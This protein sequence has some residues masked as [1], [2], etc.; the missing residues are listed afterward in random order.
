[1]NSTAGFNM[2]IKMSKEGTF[3]EV[4]E[5][6]EAFRKAITMS[7]VEGGEKGYEHEEDEEE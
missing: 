3:G 4:E 6:D 5:E 7:Q 2:A 1:M